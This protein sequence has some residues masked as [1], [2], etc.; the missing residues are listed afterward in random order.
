MVTWSVWKKL[1][2]VVAILAVVVG[3]GT[4][5]SAFASDKA[6]PADHCPDQATDNS[7]TNIT[8]SGLA[9]NLTAPFGYG[10]GTRAIETT[11]TAVLGN[12]QGQHGLPPVLGV[13]IIRPTTS[14]GAHYLGGVYGVATQLQSTSTYDLVICIPASTAVPGSYTGQLVFP[15]ASVTNNA[16]PTIA[17]SFQARSLPYVLFV[18]G[19][20]LVILGM[21]YSTAVLVRRAIHDVTLPGLFRQVTYELWSVN[22]LFALIASLGAVFGA[23]EV[24]CFR[25][26]TWG[27]PWPDILVTVV[28]LAGAAGAASTV[29]MG[30]SMGVIRPQLNVR[31]TN[32]MPALIQPDQEA[33]E[34]EHL[35]TSPPGSASDILPPNPTATDD[36]AVPTL[37]PREPV[38]RLTFSYDGPDITLVSDQLT[39]V[40]VPPSHPLGE[41]GTAA[42]FSVVL[43][44][45]QNRPLYYRVGTSPV[46]FDAEVFA[47]DSPESSMSRVSVTH[48]TGT[49]VLLV[50]HIPG[51][52]AVELSGHQTGAEAT[53]AGPPPVA[54]FM[55]AQ[56]PVQS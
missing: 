45:T 53:A 7:W 44:D 34:T 32:Q 49:F 33:I 26:P 27:T 46:R 54:R 17:V 22:G 8:V 50:P 31:A 4:W 55:L 43:R 11:L 5:A 51:A 42:G 38:H 21:I 37:Q 20:L 16:N 19:P 36:Q 3:L 2:L 18:G 14:D 15:G 48:P 9:S 1:L 10:R 39:N 13:T 47:E 24:Q 41:A 52:A 29:P 56:P 40:I 30:L 25:D 35:W 12:A 28:T 23:W 6:N